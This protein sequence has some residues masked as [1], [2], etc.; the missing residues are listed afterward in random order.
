MTTI[1]PRRPGRGHGQRTYSSFQEIADAIEA[2]AARAESTFLVGIDG[3]GGSGKSTLAN[4]LSEALDNTT[5]IH[6][7]D[8][9]VWTDESHWSPARFAERVIGPLSAGLSAKYQRYDWLTGSFEEWF[10]IAPDHILIVEGVTALSPDL[11][12]HWHVSVWVECPRELRLERGVERDGES[13]R[14][15]WEDVWMPGE[16]DYMKR[17]RPREAAQFVYDGSGASDEDRGLSS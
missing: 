16:D 5:V 9:G 6:I 7:D 8:F 10:E 3:A 2:A 12:E 14:S 15:Q 1:P 4:K 11:R 13:M 17:N